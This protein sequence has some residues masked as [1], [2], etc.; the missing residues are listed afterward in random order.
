MDTVNNAKSGRKTAQELKDG[1]AKGRKKHHIFTRDEIQRMYKKSIE[2]FR[3]ALDLDVP[4]GIF[5][6]IKA[7]SI[8]VMSVVIAYAIGRFRISIF[9]LVVLIYAIVFK[10]KRSMEKFKASLQA[11]VH[12]QARKEKVVN[13]WE[14]VEWI[15]YMLGRFWKVLEPTVSEE[16]F[17]NV[18][19][20]FYENPPP[21]LKHIR[22]TEFTLG[23]LP[24]KIVG[25][26]FDENVEDDAVQLDTELLF[27]PLETSKEAHNFFQKGS[28]NAE[29]DSKVT[30]ATRVGGKMNFNVDLPISVTKI[31]FKTKIRVVL[32]MVKKIFLVKEVEICLLEEPYIDFN[33]KPL[34]F[35]DV[36]DLPG[37]STWI[38]SMIFTALRMNLINPQSLKINL[39]EL[40]ENKHEPMGVVCLQLLDFESKEAEQYS[41]EIDVDGKRLFKTCT[42]DDMRFSFSEFFYISVTKSDDFVGLTLDSGSKTLR[43]NIP[44]AKMMNGNKMDTMRLL[45]SEKV[46]ATLRCA[47]HYHPLV[48]AEGKK[49][50][51]GAALVTMT[52]VQIEDLRVINSSK[53]AYTTSCSIIVSPDK[54]ENNKK[55]ETSFLIK[56]TVN[57]TANLLG[58]IIDT[59]VG[60]SK[61]KKLLPSSRSTLFVHNTKSIVDSASPK[62]NDKCMFFSR[63]IAADIIK[64]C[65]LD[66]DEENAKILGNVEIP[67]SNVYSGTKEWYRLN[68]VEKGKIEIH[69]EVNYVQLR[70]DEKDLYNYTK[71]L[72]IGVKDVSSIF[73]DGNYSLMLK[74][75][76]AL[77]NVDTFC[78]GVTRPNKQ[79]L[80][81]MEEKDDLTMYL[82]KQ[83]AKEES[84]V[85]SGVVLVAGKYVEGANPSAIDVPGTKDNADNESKVTACEIVMRNDGAESGSVFIE[86]Q[87]EILKDYKGVSD[88]KDEAKVIQVRFSNFH[89][90]HDDFR[91]EFRN[92]QELVA[93]SRISFNRE[94][95][96]IFTFVAG[97]DEIKAQFKS[98]ALGKDALIGECIIPKRQVNEKFL[99]NDTGSFCTVE[100]HVQCCG[101]MHFP[102][103][104]RGCLK[105]T[106]NSV[107]DLKSSQQGLR[108]S[109]CKIYMNQV[110]IHRTKIIKK[111]LNPAFNEE[112]LFLVDKRY[113]VLKISV[114]EWSQFESST[115]L[116]T[117]ETPLYFLEEGVHVHKLSLTDLA[118]H[119]PTGSYVDAT[120]EFTREEMPKKKKNLL[121][122][123]LSF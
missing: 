5:D 16:V 55:E 70:E 75:R 109:Y 15:N 121:G 18:N 114:Y 95:K 104:K 94:I 48:K 47:T 117:V 119:Q 17:R 3:N 30:L 45:D 99:L 4:Q 120:F 41:G 14:T 86:V 28:R 111:S 29:Y 52:V 19:T 6:Y 90:M 108:D 51:A 31:A 49:H 69:F 78:T 71:I 62:F 93:C 36:M 98:L 44:I 58:G 113:D 7:P 56:N 65:I 101:F 100:A 43:G 67:M 112:V 2:E 37:L 66:S 64:V 92:A 53:N 46:K 91:I 38:R 10:F 97:H 12:N 23:S 74:N 9:F 88:T 116:G 79:I 106:L 107:Q 59:L 11:L 105:L 118:T 8:V 115:V 102:S 68:E 33:L 123:I 103:L 22:L 83:N 54:L 81:P 60:F 87:E 76:G 80:V 21:F 77:F 39:E 96:D 34:G 110:Q 122:S 24:P 26:M 35:V 61:K 20:L 50:L 82:Y 72:N 63:N 57:A 40:M 13:N 25:V 32:T 85:G 27:V 1:D 89:G 84:F 42:R 73:G